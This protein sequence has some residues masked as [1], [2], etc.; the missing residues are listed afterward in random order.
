MPEPL[1]EYLSALARRRFVLIEYGVESTLDRSL[2]RIQRR[3]SRPRAWRPSSVH[4]A[5]IIFRAHII[6]GLPG[7]AV[8]ATEPYDRLGRYH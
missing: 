5:G 2:E 4:R 8:K 1:L 3:R 7:E 6:L